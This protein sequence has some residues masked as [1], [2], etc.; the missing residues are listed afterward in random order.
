MIALD[1]VVAV[2]YATMALLVIALITY[3]IVGVLVILKR[4]K[5]V[6]AAYFA[7]TPMIFLVGLAL[8]RI[9]NS[10]DFIIT[11]AAVI[12]LFNSLFLLGT[13]RFQKRA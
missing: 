10:P 2:F 6:S 1:G 11:S 5:L 13:R 12:I 7:I 8:T 9:F 3:F 4:Q